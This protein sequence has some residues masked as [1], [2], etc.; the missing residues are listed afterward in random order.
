M[1]LRITTNDIQVPVTESKMEM[2]AG[3]CSVCGEMVRWAWH[4]G[5]EPNHTL[6]ECLGNIVE[7]ARRP[8]GDGV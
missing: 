4:R 6:T 8:M 1:A 2:G 3:Y 5:E 7:K